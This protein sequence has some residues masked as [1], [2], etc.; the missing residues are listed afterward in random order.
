MTTSKIHEDA[1]QGV[2]SADA[3]FAGAS[4]ALAGVHGNPGVRQ[5]LEHQ[6]AV[7]DGR[8]QERSAAPDVLDDETTL[9]SDS[10]VLAA[11][12]TVAEKAAKKDFDSALEAVSAQITVLG[13]EL[14]MTNLEQADL[15]GNAHLP[16]IRGGSKS[17][18][19][20][21][22]DGERLRLKIALVVSL[23]DVGAASGLGRHP[24][25]LIVDSIAREE[26]NTANGQSLLSELERVA[27]AYDLQV[28]TGTAHSDLVD[29]V[30]PPEAVVRPLESRLMW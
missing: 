29:A 30:L 18:F 4:E 10:E 12:V 25:F 1:K 21:L 22:T 23:L 8:I 16:V 13:R 17:N 27:S 6:L 11:T 26:L 7:L 2:A 24:G 19:G 15:K 14:G 5:S 20:G 28:I 9:A 3:E